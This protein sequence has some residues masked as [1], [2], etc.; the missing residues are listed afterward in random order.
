[1]RFTKMQ[2]LGNDYV[3]INGMKETVEDP[4]KLAIRFSDR[5]FGIGA[6]GL[7]V[8]GASKVAD[9]RMEMYNADGSRGMM[10]G[11]GIRCV[12]KYAYEQGIVPKKTIRIETLSGI[13]ETLILS[14]GDVQVNMG[15]PKV[16]RIK[17]EIT[18]SVLGGKRITSDCVS[19]GNPH[20]ILY[21]NELQ[22]TEQME[23][24][25][26]ERIGPALECCSGEFHRRNVEVVNVLDR[27][28]LE[29][30][31]W[32]RGTGET[33]ACGTGACAAAVS[34]IVRN[35]TEREVRIKLKGGN[36]L[37]KWGEDSGNLYMTGPAVTVFKG[38]I[39]V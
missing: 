29:M 13:K 7:I 38:D 21:L 39:T 6:D 10:C 4:E 22:E 1:M 16:E 11:N 9:V 2:G 32:E 28:T 20:R 3:Y 23:C 27:N 19:M 37:V 8:I 5:H 31:V 14:D 18:I 17:Q 25:E 33:L 12:A 30:R 24:L 15:E 35:L 36:L 34:S 26:L